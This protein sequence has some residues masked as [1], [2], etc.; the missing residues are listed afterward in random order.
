[1]LRLGFVIAAPA[2]IQSLRDVLGDW[3]VSVDA[4]TAGMHAYAD[5]AWMTGMREQLRKQATR[6]DDMLTG[7]GFRI[8]G[9]TSLFR[10]ASAPDAKERFV[11]LL[12]QGVLSRPFAHDATL[13]RFGL[14]HHDEWSR[15][16]EVL[17]AV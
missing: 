11:Q 15:V 8:V 12:S 13:L 10:L 3:P 14:P 5:R 6:V 7:A 9:G 4:I 16:G 1:G 2:I 17:G